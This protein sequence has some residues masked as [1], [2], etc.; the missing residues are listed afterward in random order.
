M[1]GVM[2]VDGKYTA[3]LIL[4]GERVFHG[5]YDTFEE[6]VSARREA[7]DT[8]L[9][10]LFE[11]WR[12]EKKSD[13]EMLSALGWITCEEARKEILKRCGATISLNTIKNYVREKKIE[14]GILGGMYGVSQEWAMTFIPRRKKTQS[15]KN[16]IL[17]LD[18]NNTL[19]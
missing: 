19:M 5:V 3:T 16:I 17:P 18:K 4:R 12:H 10:P 14:G 1:R 7:E 11:K 6:A 8:Y 9:K 13:E 15:Q 2:K